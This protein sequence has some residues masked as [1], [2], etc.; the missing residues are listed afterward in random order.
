MFMYSL[1][2]YHH[3]KKTCRKIYS[4]FVLGINVQTTIRFD[5]EYTA[6]LG[7]PSSSDFK[8]LKSNIDTKVSTF[9]KGINFQFLLETLCS[10]VLAVTLLLSSS[11]EETV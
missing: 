7:D 5:K 4:S 2:S 8:E 6:N 1:L 9:Q 3:T 11:V 10:N